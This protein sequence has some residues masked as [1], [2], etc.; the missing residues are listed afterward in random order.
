MPN[1]PLN[2]PLSPQAATEIVAPQALEALRA[3]WTALWRRCPAATPFQAPEWVLPWARHHAPGRCGAIALRQGGRLVALAP[4]FCWQGALLLAGTGP[5]DRAAVLTDPQAGKAGPQLLAALPDAAP[6]AFDRVDLQQ[7]PCSSPLWQSD[8]PPGWRDERCPGDAC[9][10]APLSGP[11]GL[12]AVSR[13]R[14]ANWRYALRRLGREGG[15]AGRV[16]ESEIEDAMDD[17][18][19]LHSSR[20]RARGEAGVLSDPLLCDFLLDAAPA[21][22]RAGLLRLYQV[23]LAEQRIAVLMVLAGQGAH[24]YYIGGFDP[25]H[26]KLSPSAVLIGTAMV[27]AYQEG[28]P[29]F[30]FLR[31]AEPYKSDWGARERKMHRRILAPPAR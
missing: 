13:R 24:H 14:R 18:V 11:D 17:L 9:L 26:A 22:D 28:A 19:H 23:R 2:A 29:E 31:G 30:D 7:L 20:W 25:D 10:V 12:G 16:E 8:A 4:V 1:S 15:V 21:L 27:Q 5:S 6:E 3:E